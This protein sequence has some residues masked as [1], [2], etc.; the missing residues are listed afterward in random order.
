[1]LQATEG[2]FTADD[3]LLPD[4]VVEEMLRGMPHA[5]CVPIPACNH[6]TIVFCDSAVRDQALHQFLA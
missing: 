6:Y 3:L 2:M 4:A 1:M 5:I